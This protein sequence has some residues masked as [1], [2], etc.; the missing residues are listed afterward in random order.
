LDASPLCDGHLAVQEKELGRA[1][2]EDLAWLGHALA[3]RA[4]EESG[5][6]DKKTPRGNFKRYR[7]PSNERQS[8]GN[9]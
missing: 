4:H 6:D 2:V 7:A 5:T 1:G 8:R 9:Q 3:L